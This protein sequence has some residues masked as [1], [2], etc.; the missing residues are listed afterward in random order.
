MDLTIEGKVF[1]NGKFEKC[2]IGIEDGKISKIKRILKSDNHQIF[3]NNLILPGGLDMHVHF[4]DPGMTH[5][6]DFST[7]SKAAAFG[8]ITC[9]F[10][11]PNTIP[12]TTTKQKLIDKIKIGENKSYVD[13][14]IY[15]G[16][17]N[18]NL[19]EISDMDRYC[20]GFK[21]YMAESTNSMNF[22]IKNLKL[23]KN[24]DF[25]NKPILI[26]AEDNKY[27]N[28]RIKERNL[29]EHNISRP[30]ISEIKAIDNIISIFKDSKLR[31]HICHISS[32]DRI[33][34]IRNL[35]NITCG[36][37]PHHLFLNIENKKKIQSLYKVNP[38]IREKLRRE[39]LF[40]YLKENK[41]DVIESDH[42][43]HSFHEKNV[44]FD[45]APSGIPGVE[46]MIPIF[47][48]LIKK[49]IISVTQFLNLFC[50]KPSKILGVPKGKIEVGRDADFIIVDLNKSTKIN[51]EE[52]HYKCGWT[53]FE[54]FHAIFPKH[55][56]LRGKQLIC[57]GELMTNKS[58][59]KFI[60]G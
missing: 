18:D 46:T 56:F 3:K 30:S 4:R 2:C 20:S 25:S 57:D 23:L 58:S 10:D 60:G 21:L 17:T 32:S 44:N 39:I 55:V 53:P 7:G 47:L 49:G 51:S 28:N 35:H 8:G 59:G 52:L 45:E 34:E 40:R 16:L 50:E 9:F 12:L 19:D 27:F 22:N 42:A 54:N 24:I 11:M 41:I 14:G 48:F 1:S 29:I 26:H 43:P 13:F 38:P 15:S 31:I 36:I 37:T 6:E 33:D 5:K